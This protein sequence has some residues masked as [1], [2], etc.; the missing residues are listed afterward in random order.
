[1][2]SDSWVN[3]T[4]INQSDLVKRHAACHSEGTSKKRKRRSSLSGRTSVACTACAAAKIKCENDKPCLR[5]LKKGTPC[6]PV[7][8]EML[9]PTSNPD[10]EGGTCLD[11]IDILYCSATKELQT[12][13]VM[14][15][16]NIRP[17]CHLYGLSQSSNLVTMPRKVLCITVM[18]YHN[19]QIKTRAQVSTLTSTISARKSMIIHSM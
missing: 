10:V 5:C 18:F 12:Y 8:D 15:L 14:S 11:P 17:R 9:A 7:N 1:M 16:N 6:I 2:L 13:L 3:S 19:R 4:L